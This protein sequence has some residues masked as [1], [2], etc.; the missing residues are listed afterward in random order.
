MQE[1][2]KIA[3][4]ESKEPVVIITNHFAKGQE[5]KIAYANE[6][7]L[8]LVGYTI[9]EVFNTNPKEI[10]T[11]KLNEN[12]VEEIK[13]AVMQ[14]TTW[15]GPIV[16]HGKNGSNEVLYFN[17][18][19]VQ[20]VANE[21][22]YYACFGNR[23]EA[24][25][26]QLYNKA[27]KKHLDNFIN[28]LF[29]QTNYFKDFSDNLPTGIW[30]IDANFNVVYANQIAS[31]IFGFAQ[32]TNLFD[33][34][35]HAEHGFVRTMLNNS[36]SEQKINH[37]TFRVKKEGTVIWAGCDFWPVIE[38]NQLVGYSGTAKNVTNEALL[39]KQLQVFKTN[40]TATK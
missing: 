38:N 24:A 20:N 10:F 1:L 29:A 22:M 17:I 9:D 39:V 11:N 13:Q 32:D 30:R 26:G 6:E 40:A 2:I 19:P 37:M 8:S 23:I 31:N 36:G 3:I 34:I 18:V 33:A 7:F 4:A 14:H 15:E 5:P 27:S 16:V 28:T 25:S 12:I 35:L 21:T